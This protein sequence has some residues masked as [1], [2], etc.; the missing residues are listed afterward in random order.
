MTSFR[1]YHHLLWVKTTTSD[2]SKNNESLIMAS[3]QGVTNSAWPNIRLM[4]GPVY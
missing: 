1:N 4:T 2:L 3:N